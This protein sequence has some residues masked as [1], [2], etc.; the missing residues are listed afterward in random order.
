[1]RPLRHPLHLPGLPILCSR[2]QVSDCPD[3]RPLGLSFDGHPGPR[4]APD[5]AAPVG[6][7]AAVADIW[8]CPIPVALRPCLFE[9]TGLS[10][11]PAVVAG[12]LPRRRYA[13]PPVPVLG[14]IQP[15]AP[16]PLRWLA[17][18]PPLLRRADPAGN[19]VHH[20]LGELEW[21]RYRP[22]FKFSP[23]QYRLLP[24]YDGKLTVWLETLRHYI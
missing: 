1:M 7:T 10:A 12:A 11:L 14:A 6:P 4:T 15:S 17:N 20:C 19:V 5:G 21:L 2:R 16:P 23:I 24:V 22:R 18:Q 13:R 8:R 3:L 9:S